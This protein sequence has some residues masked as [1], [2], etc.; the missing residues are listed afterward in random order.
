MST[1]GNKKYPPTGNR[2]AQGKSEKPG[3]A[4]ILIGGGVILLL[5]AAV[6]VYTSSR[7]PKSDLPLEVSSAPALKVDQERIDFGDVKVD[8]PVTAR[9]EI[10]NVGDQ[11]LRFSQVPKV[12]VVEGC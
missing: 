2:K 9:F 3:P 7:S 6:F 4:I 10:A 5:L 11:P 12:E 8:T 1:S